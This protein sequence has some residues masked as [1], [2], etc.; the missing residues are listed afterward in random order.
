MTLGDQ[1]YA[2]EDFIGREREMVQLT[3]T[4]VAGRSACLVGPEGS[5]KSLLLLHLAHSAAIVLDTPPP[6]VWVDARAIRLADAPD[7]PC[8]Q[9]NRPG[10]DN[11]GQ[12]EDDC[13]LRI[14]RPASTPCPTPRY[15]IRANVTRPSYAGFPFH[16]RGM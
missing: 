1:R 2:A 3:E 6:I 12:V 7:H 10:L 14:A 11:G 8:V 4:L 13:L 5:G 16:P 15:M 9:I